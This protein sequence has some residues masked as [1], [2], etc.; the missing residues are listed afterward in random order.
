[1]AKSNPN[2]SRVIQVNAGIIGPREPRL[3]SVRPKKI[4]DYPGIPVA[5][6]EVAKS[7]SHRHAT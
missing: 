4:S 5:Y 1:M 2:D 7:Y 3:R 6:L